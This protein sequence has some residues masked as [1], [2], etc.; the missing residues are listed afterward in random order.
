VTGLLIAPLPAA[1]TDPTSGRAEH[2]CGACGYGV[3]VSDP[4]PA[5]P[6]CQ[7]HN[8]EPTLRQ[9]LAHPDRSGPNAVVDELAARRLRPR[10]RR[11]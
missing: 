5:C 10:R 2:R 9:P 1:D 7:S 3:V 11:R 6:M 4:L 8:W